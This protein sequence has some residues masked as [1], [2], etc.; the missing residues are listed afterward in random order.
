MAVKDALK[1]L[2]GG[3]SSLY[4]EELHNLCCSCNIL[5][6]IRSRRGIRTLYSEERLEPGEILMQTGPVLCEHLRFLRGGS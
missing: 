6:V 1:M 3:G 2:S 5:W 4:I